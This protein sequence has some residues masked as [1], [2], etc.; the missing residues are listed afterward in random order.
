MSKMLGF[1]LVGV[2]DGEAEVNVLLDGQE[3][4]QA[5]FK[6]QAKC[7]DRLRKKLAAQDSERL[8][9]LLAETSCLPFLD[10]A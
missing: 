7:Y 3:W 2:A 4:V 9:D 6:Y 5:P 10:S 1:P 8:R